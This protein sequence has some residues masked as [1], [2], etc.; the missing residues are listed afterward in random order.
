MLKK[1]INDF[2]NQYATLARDDEDSAYIEL[3]VDNH[4]VIRWEGN[5]YYLPEENSLWNEEENLL[6]EMLSNT[7]C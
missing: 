3:M 5:E 4:H 1:L 2:L 6:A 7:F